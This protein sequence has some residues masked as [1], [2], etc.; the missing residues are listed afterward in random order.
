MKVFHLI[1]RHQSGGAELAAASMLDEPGLSGRFSLMAISGRVPLVGKH[2]RSI[3]SGYDGVNNPLGYLMILG[4]LLKAKPDYLVCSLWRSCLVGLLYKVFNPKVRLVFFRH[5]ERCQH[6]VESITQRL[7]LWACWCVLADSLTSAKSLNTKKYTLVISFLLNRYHVAPSRP[8][9][10]DASFIFWGC[11]K[12]QKRVDRAIDFIHKLNMRGVGATLKVYGS[13]G[14]ELQNLKDQVARIGLE[15]KISFHGVVPHTFLMDAAAD[16]SFYLQL[17]QYEGFSMSTAEAMQFG[18]LPVVTPVGEIG[19]Y[20]ID[21]ENAIVVT[22]V[23]D[24]DKSIDKVMAVLGSQSCFDRLVGNS[25]TTWSG[26]GTYREE[27]T[28]FIESLP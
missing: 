22:D 28:A 17:S 6:F 26:C 5:N 3:V 13:D 18:L 25:A 19:N 9:P 12:R 7:S 4:I 8:K 10:V 24:L 14:G 23:G 16:Y 27:F 1:P 15:D 2:S 21:N 20:C 11:A